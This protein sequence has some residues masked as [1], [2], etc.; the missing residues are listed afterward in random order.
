MGWAVGIDVGGTYTDVVL[1]APDGRVTVAKAATTPR[2]QSEG[3]MEGI[4]LA[5]E[6]VGRSVSSLLADTRRIV[7]GTTVATN[8]LLERKTARVGLLITEGHRDVVDMREGLKPDRY[9]LRMPAPVPLVPRRLRLPVRERMRADGSVEL[10]LDI[11]SVERALDTLEAERVQAVAICLL[12]AWRNPTHEF[13]VAEAVRRRLP[14]AFVTISSEVLPQ[15]KEFER[16]S[17]SVANAMVGPII[18]DYLQRL[19]VRLQEAG[20]AGSLFVIMSHGGIA[21]ASEASRLAIATALSGPAGGVAAALA[22]SKTGIGTELITFDMGGTSTDIALVRG[23]RAGLSGGRFVA[24]A[25]IALPMLDIV[26]IG[27][28]GGSIARLDRSGLLQVGPESA[29]A[30]PGPACYGLGGTLPTVT[31]ANLCLGYLDALLGG[32]RRLDRSAS[33]RAIDTL[34]VALGLSRDATGAGIYRVVNA[35]MAD[36]VRIATVKR[37]VDPREHTLLAFGGA[38]GLHVCAVAA[39]LGITR[40]IIPLHASVLSAWGMLNTDLRVELIRSQPQA[41]GIAVGSLRAAFANMEAEGRERLRWFDG[42]LETGRSADMRYG[43][44]VFEISVPLAGCFD[45]DDA[46]VA[47]SIS[48]AFHRRHQEL[49]TYALRDQEIVL[50]NARCSVTGRFPRAAPL[51]SATPGLWKATGTRPVYLG[52]WF[53]VPVY[54]F[55]VLGKEEGVGP[56]IIEASTTTALLRANDRATFDARGWLEVTV[57]T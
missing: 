13:A 17:A 24:D 5:A 21:S 8:A 4:R 44:Q 19:Q 35:R 20:F 9:N 7:H 6:A 55:E 28:G 15:I 25:R 36:G 1:A 46:A 23:G 3:V 2:D 54:R 40:V 30:D 29:G 31:D 50:V 39:E 10:P 57:G 34:A 12:H 56:C 47:A 51:R 14:D 37:G 27:A 22:L 11:A 43:E 26:T 38:A 41:G 42:P 52:E 18:H 53:E 16:F 49:Y 32:R 33:E 45:G 48:E